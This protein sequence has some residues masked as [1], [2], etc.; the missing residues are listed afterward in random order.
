MLVRV[1]L[2]ELL[3]PINLVGVLVPLSTLP[4]DLS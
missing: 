2:S 3:L 1:F 4:D